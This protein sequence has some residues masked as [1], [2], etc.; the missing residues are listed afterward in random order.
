[1]R[2]TTRPG[3][4]DPPPRSCA[5]FRMAFPTNVVTAW[6][7]VS[8]YWFDLATR[9]PVQ[10]PGTDFLEQNIRAAALARSPFELI[11]PVT[12][13]PLFKR[14]LVV[15]AFESINGEHLPDPNADIQEH[16]PVV[17]ERFD[18]FP[19]EG[20]RRRVRVNSCAKEKLRPVHISDAGDDG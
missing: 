19:A 10:L 7:M 18:S 11:H 9:T 16:H 2:S 6:R 3:N 13:I 20:V 17:P 1:M 15:V 4:A 14:P 5:T 12:V 8:V